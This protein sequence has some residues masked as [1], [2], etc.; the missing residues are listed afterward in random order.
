MAFP[1][2][3]LGP[4]IAKRLSRMDV[5]I[6]AN[7]CLNCYDAPC[8]RACPTGIDVPRFIGRI[9]TGDLLGSAQTIMDANP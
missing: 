1:S 3:S 8:I 5:Q 9:A 7:R 2:V 6:E 4:P